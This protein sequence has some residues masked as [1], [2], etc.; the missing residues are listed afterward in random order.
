MTDTC[1]SRDVILTALCD[2]FWVPTEYVEFALNLTTHQCMRIFD[3]ART[4]EWWS[5]C[6]K[7]PEERRL[8]GQCITTYYGVRGIRALPGHPK[9][10]DCKRS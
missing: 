9:Y 7:T 6:G 8:N 3:F 1:P 4:A 2:G 5:I 10:F